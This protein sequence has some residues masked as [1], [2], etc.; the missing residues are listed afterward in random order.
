MSAAEVA[1]E[2]EIDGVVGLGG[3]SVL[4]AAKGVA[5]LT[6]N[7]GRAEHYEGETRYAEPPVPL[8]AVPSTCGTGSEV[9]WVAVLN[10]KPTQAKISIKGETMFPDY[11]LVDA[12]LLATLPPRL[13]AW[14]GL[15]ALTHA[16][17]ATTC[18][19]ANPVSDALAEKAITLLFTYLPRAFADIGG[20]AEAREAV[21]RA[22]TLAGLAFGS[23]DVAAVHCLSESIGGRFDFSHGLLNAILL[24]PIL[25]Y[26]RRHIRTRLAELDQLLAPPGK[27]DPPPG[28]RASRFLKRIGTLTRKL[29]LPS[30]GSLGIPAD[31]YP[32][33]A[34]GAVRNGSNGSNPQPMATCDYRAVLEDLG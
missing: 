5:M 22:S 9:T 33:I 23:S 11:A 16:I 21:M 8:V 6:T 2:K 32:A 28:R 20:D 27:T 24:E 34:E 15:D 18:Q 19:A 30:F 12:D 7:S 31:Q 25:H 1:R 17:E 26:H 3:G 13:V 4:D 29:E 14:T 10:H